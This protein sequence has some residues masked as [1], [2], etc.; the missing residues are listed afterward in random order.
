MN[1]IIEHINSAGY[2]FVGFAAAMLIQSGL[3]ILLLLLA[4]FA[5]RKRV[6]AVFRY[7]IWMLVLVKLVL[8]TSLAGPFSLGYWFGDEIASVDVSHS[9][10]EAQP[11]AGEA[12]APVLPHIIDLS[13]VRPPMYRPSVTPSPSE[14]D[15]APAESIAPPAVPITWQ[16]VVFL[17]WLAI[18]AVMLLLLGQR[19]IFV[20][21][22]VAQAKNA[23]RPML[24]TLDQCRKSIKIKRAVTVK[25]SPNAT[26]PAVCGLW[27]PV[28]LIPHNMPAALGSADL[29][30][31]LLHELAHIK[32]GDLWVNL[33][34]TLLQIVYFYNPLLWLANAVIRRAREQAVDEAVL[35]A[36]GEKA[37]Q[38]PQALVSV[39]KL[40]FKRPTLSLRLIG[41]VESKS[42]LTARIKRILSRPIPKSAKLGI[43]GLLAVII[44]AVVLLPMTRAER[45]IRKYVRP[46]GFQARLTNGVTVELVG[47]C[48]YPSA[49]RQWWRPDGSLLEEAPSENLKVGGFNT[50]GNE[51][52]YELVVK[53]EGLKQL[54]NRSESPDRWEVPQAR[55]VGLGSSGLYKDRSGQLCLRATTAIVKKGLDSVDVAF[56]IGW[57]VKERI[58]ISS[59]EK[60]KQ[61]V[62]GIGVV[63]EPPYEK[64]GKPAVTIKIPNKTDQRMTVGVRAVLKDGSTW[65]NA[66][67]SRNSKF[68]FAASTDNYEFAGITLSQ[69]DH[70]EIFTIEYEWI[71][72]KNVSLRPNCTT[73]ANGVTVELVGVCEHPSDGKQWWKPGGDELLEAPYDEIGGSVY[74]G[75]D[76]KSFEFAIKL[77]NLP[78]EHVNT[79]V[80]CEESVG[81]SAGGSSSPEKTGEYLSDFRWLATTFPTKLKACTVK[82]GVAAGQWQAVAESN[83]KGFGSRGSE[84]G[85]VSFTKAFEVEDGISITVADDILGRPCRVV[86]ITN[87]GE[88]VKPVGSSGSSAGKARQTTAKFNNISLSDIKEFQFQTR[89]YEW[90][91]FKHVSLRPGVKTDVQV[92]VENDREKGSQFVVTSGNGVEI[93][94]RELIAKII[95]SEKKIKDI[96]LQMTCTIGALDRTFYEYDWGYEDTKE[97]LSGTTNT[98]DSRTGVYRSV[99]VIRAFDGKRE[100]LF[101]ND[102]KSSRPH[103]GITKPNPNFPFSGGIMTFNTL[104]ARLLP[105]Y[106]I[107]LPDS[108][109]PAVSSL[110]WAIVF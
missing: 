74:P 34:Q 57:Q 27:R 83:G 48:E 26:S 95:E 13:K 32:R 28:I 33:I 96:R 108:G 30:V 14:T 10:S 41:V 53:V 58:S 65:G 38:Y 82:V 2:A 66:A 3:L 45:E 84:L 67:W 39:A 55:K 46:D 69:V 91:E 24:D 87:D 93:S 97:F 104:L 90:A 5:L 23:N 52:A 88:V 42:A 75:G 43:F 89:P 16:G 85:G 20:R 61:R 99:K 15:L 25:V 8:P 100:W 12:P 6:R 72:F 21:G 81:G 1:A 107:T 62:E 18:A 35:V 9:T 47:V 44:A 103:G 70:F 94:A 22:L 102:P 68:R 92:E 106:I 110:I 19:A 51:A 63:V 105:F 36:M 54:E 37:S 73:L 56:G 60:S 59:G 49:G 40:V 71:E 101:R 50:K 31:V 79:K 78:A 86:A 11:Q 29:R 98:K 109:S 7:W 4:D 17:L 77:R 80:R 64:N 76:E